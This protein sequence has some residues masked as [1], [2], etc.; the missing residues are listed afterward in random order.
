MQESNI[1]DNSKSTIPIVVDSNEELLLHKKDLPN[2][3]IL[4]VAEDGSLEM[5]EMEA[6]K[7]KNAN[8]KGHES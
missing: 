3:Q 2:K 5:M 8:L 7:E 4:T 6:W 1:E